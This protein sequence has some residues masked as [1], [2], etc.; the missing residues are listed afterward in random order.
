M[1]YR[2]LGRTGLRI[3]VVTLGTMGF[4][5]TGWAEPVGQIDV[6]GA[7]E[8]IAMARDAGVNMIDTADVYSR[9][10]VRHDRHPAV[11]G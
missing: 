11:A 9:M 7:K 8:Q 3:S 6:P 10:G 2:Q 1:E 5:G 4:G